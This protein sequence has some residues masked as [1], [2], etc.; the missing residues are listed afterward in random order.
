MSCLEDLSD[1][2][3]DL[4]RQLT[5]RMNRRQRTARLPEVYNIDALVG[6]T[7]EGYVVADS[8]ATGTVSLLRVCPGHDAS[9]GQTGSALRLRKGEEYTGAA[10]DSERP[11]Y[12]EGCGRELVVGGARNAKISIDQPRRRRSA[13]VRG[14]IAYF[15]QHTRLYDWASCGLGVQGGRALGATFSR[16]MRDGAQEEEIGRM[17]DMFF[18]RLPDSRVQKTKVKQPWSMFISQRIA[19]RNMQ[20]REQQSHEQEAQRLVN[21]VRSETVSEDF[22]PV[23]G[24]AALRQRRRQSSRRKDR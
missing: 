2:E 23:V 7:D 22:D 15:E 6:L 4:L 1:V 12:A 19:L 17:I 24:G 21:R 3:H 16:W 20:L 14:L 10:G 18:D 11:P 5:K 13:S 9:P 8:A